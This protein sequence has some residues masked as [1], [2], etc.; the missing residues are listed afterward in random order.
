MLDEDIVALAK[1]FDII[2]TSS[3]VAHD[4]HEQVVDLQEMPT[5]PQYRQELLS[6]SAQDPRENQEQLQ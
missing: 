2:L 3:D 5:Y 6:S 4:A 1:W